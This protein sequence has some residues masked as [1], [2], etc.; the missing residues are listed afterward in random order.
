M[1]VAPRH[2]SLL[3]MLE[4]GAG[5]VAAA[6]LPI[7]ARPRFPGVAMTRPFNYVYDYLVARHDDDTLLGIRGPRRTR[8]D[9]KPQQCS[10]A[11]PR[12][13]SRVRPEIRH[14]SRTRGRRRR[15]R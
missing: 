9:G 4:R 1:V 7:D 6:S 2:A 12:V 3:E 14:R 10:L 15:K 8:R 13:A 5:D 11:H